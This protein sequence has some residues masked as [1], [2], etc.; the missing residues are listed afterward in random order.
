MTASPHRQNVRLNPPEN[1]LALP[2]RP[3]RE[4]RASDPL[5]VNKE[6]A[7]YFLESHPYEGQRELDP[8]WVKELEGFLRKGDWR[9]DAIEI[10]WLDGTGHM[11]NGRHR[12][13]A[14]SNCAIPAWMFLQQKRVSS[15]EELQDEYARCDRGRMRNVRDALHAYGVDKDIPDLTFV[16][17]AVNGIRKEWGFTRRGAKRLEIRNPEFLRDAVMEWRPWA[18]KYLGLIKGATWIPGK[19][20]KSA[21]VMS[22]AMVTLRYVGTDAE[23]FWKMCAK[24]DPLPPKE[25]PAYLLGRI[26]GPSTVLKGSR[27]PTLARE[28]ASVWNSYYQ[29]ETRTKRTTVDLSQP[30]KLLGTPYEEKKPNEE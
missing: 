28:V 1:L 8:W 27:V 30:I 29:G 7:D 17:A 11:T 3:L 25:H 5:L 21:G 23:E 19:R 24:G 9:E 16:A 15:V 22:I 4:R 14:V 20:L 26:L 18:V 10:V 13:T 2:L 12:C 6:I